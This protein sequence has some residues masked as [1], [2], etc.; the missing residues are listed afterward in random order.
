MSSSHSL[1]LGGKQ[2]GP[3]GAGM[4]YAKA[5]TLSVFLSQH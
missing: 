1:P 3:H 2:E 4:S 5:K